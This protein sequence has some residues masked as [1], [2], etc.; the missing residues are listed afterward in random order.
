MIIN[1]KIEESIYKYIFFIF[2]YLFK[3]PFQVSQITPCQCIPT[4]KKKA[5]EDS[6]LYEELEIAAALSRPSDYPTAC[7]E[8]SAMLSASAMPIYQSASDLSFF[9]RRFLPFASSRSKLLYFYLFFYLFFFLFRCFCANF[10]IP[11]CQISV[12]CMKGCRIDQ[13]LL[14]RDNICINMAEFNLI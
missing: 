3:D 11:V 9:K 12:N 4:L 13:F 8:L 1:L 2:L 6:A 10:S 7:Y 14:G 5:P